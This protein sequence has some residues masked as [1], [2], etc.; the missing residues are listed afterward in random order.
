MI[1]L[2]TGRSAQNGDYVIGYAV[3]LGRFYFIVDR[4][5]LHTEVVKSTVKVY[6]A[7]TNIQLP[8]DC[9]VDYGEPSYIEH[10]HSLK[11]YL[12]EYEVINYQQHGACYL[13]DLQDWTDKD[14]KEV[15]NIGPVK[16]RRMKKLLE[17]VGL[18]YSGT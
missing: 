3:K 10:M 5:G 18:R 13:E 4:R 6:T 15:R 14:Y 1:L 11:D 7:G 12:T 8:I 2:H 17:E 16:R 9:R